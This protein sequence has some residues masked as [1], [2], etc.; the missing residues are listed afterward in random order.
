MSANL[1][2]STKY[3]FQ[4]AQQ[5]SP[6]SNQLTGNQETIK[7]QNW[8]LAKPSVLEKAKVNPSDFHRTI[9]RFPQHLP[10]IKPPRSSSQFILF[11]T[12]TIDISPGNILQWLFYSIQFYTLI[13]RLNNQQQCPNRQSASSA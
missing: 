13:P 5:K 7:F 4:Q 9:P 10:L 8:T 11:Y 3:H 6:D 12:L 2:T 1:R